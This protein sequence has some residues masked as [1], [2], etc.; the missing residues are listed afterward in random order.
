MG[1][2]W[3][4]YNSQPIYFINVINMLRQIENEEIDR[5]NKKNG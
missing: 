2:D 3:H 4:T 5:Q 1:W